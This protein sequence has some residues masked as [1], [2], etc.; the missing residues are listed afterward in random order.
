MLG[1]GRPGALG[2]GVLSRGL[3]GCVSSAQRWGDAAAR[4][5]HGE[6][7]CSESAWGAP[8]PASCPGGATR[9]VRPSRRAVCCVLCL[10]HGQ[11]ACMCVC[12]RA[13]ACVSM[14]SC[15]SVCTS[16]RVCTCVCGGEAP[17]RGS[18]PT[19]PGSLPLPPS[20][21]P[22]TS[23]GLPG[24]FRQ[25]LSEAGVWRRPPCLPAWSSGGGAGRDP[26]RVGEV[27][28][29]HGSEHLQLFG[30][31]MLG[32]FRSSVGGLTSGAV[33]TAAFQGGCRGCWRLRGRRG[34]H[35]ASL[36]GTAS[37]DA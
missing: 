29:P 33:G 13:C 36:G 11:R 4:S 14:C 22:L 12:A 10:D 8:V 3:S 7:P 32:T 23:V 19:G 1:A 17:A 25:P 35:R 20:S 24:P 6:P 30:G 26:R 37:P 28:T 9:E 5:G 31:G 2:L 15:V 16:V 21:R 34:T 18:E 27:H